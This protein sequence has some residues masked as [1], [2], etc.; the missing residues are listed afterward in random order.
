MYRVLLK[1]EIEALIHNGCWA[2]DWNTVF[3]SKAGFKPANYRFAIFSGNI[4]LGTTLKKHILEGGIE[5][6]SG[7]YNTKLH[8]CKIGN[9][10]YIN[11]V[12]QYIANYNIGDDVVVNNIDSLIVCGE[13]SFG[14][15]TRISVLNET[16]GRDVV[17][18]DKLS[19][20][21]AYILTLYRHHPVTLQ[22]IEE[23]INKYV[24][25]VKSSVGHI[26]NGVKVLNCG[27][28]KNVFIGDS[29]ILE[30][31]SRMTNGSI[32]SNLQAPV[33]IGRDVI[34]DNFIV[35]SS[36]RIFDGVIID[37]CFIG[38]GCEM[39]KQYSAENSLFFSN[40]VGMHGEACSIFAGPYTVTHHKSTLLI[41]GL[42]S[43]MN[44]GSGSNQSNHM[45]KLGPIHQ[46]IIDRGSK[47]TSDSYLLWP[48][49][50]GAFS[51]V[52]G[53]HYNNCDTSL[54]PFSYIIESNSKSVIVPGVNLRSVGTIRD[55]KKWPKRDKRKGE[56][57]IDQINFNL[58][59]PYT[60]HKMLKGIETLKNLIEAS[61]ETSSTYSYQSCVIKNSSLFKGIE[62]YEMAVTKFFGNSIIKRL[63]NIKG[64]S[65]DE[66]RAALLPKTAIGRGSWFDISGLIAPKSEIIRILNDIVS[67]KITSLD[68][69]HNEFITLKENYY[70]YEWSWVYDKMITNNKNLNAISVA[71]LIEYIKKWKTCVITIDKLLYNDAK[72]EFTLASKT[73]FG[74][75]GGNIDKKKDFENV[76]GDFEKNDFV[77]EVLDHIEKKSALGDELID[78]IKHLA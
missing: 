3:V 30:G 48:S 13:S 8:N 46:G 11:N 37:K 6:S 74:A 14:N 4:Y 33:Y 53:R 47:T 1:G 17:I 23:F 7:V 78:R 36:S 72:K 55:A 76:R 19:S 5:V 9:G 65:I 52:M 62:L 40:C 21:L 18:Y 44:A 77:L 75:D 67:G 10:T 68:M 26:G 70:E 56:E 2:E 73:S 27:A 54:L 16:G 22:K 32:N 63:E 69:I 60:I 20:H 51:I 58:L 42:Y 41:A 24:D 49:K 34:A 59:S 66:I 61:G 28:I 29:A 25:G 43:F 39:G 57:K 45:Y 15:G 35:C 64:D 38:Q 50:I 12:N 31:V 71:G